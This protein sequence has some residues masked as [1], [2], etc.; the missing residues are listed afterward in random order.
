MTKREVLEIFYANRFPLTPDSVYMRLRGFRRRCAVYSYLLRLYRQGLLLR[1]R[2][3][4]RIAYQI[5]PR[6]IKRLHY[7]RQKGEYR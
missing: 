2:V 4:E 3:G 5:S 7:F 1:T 6:G